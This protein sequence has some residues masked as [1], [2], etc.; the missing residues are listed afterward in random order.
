MATKTRKIGA[1]GNMT[2]ANFATSIETFPDVDTRIKAFEATFKLKGQICLDL[3]RN[4]V[5]D[6][7][8]WIARMYLNAGKKEIGEATGTQLDRVVNAVC[9][10]AWRS[11]KNLYPNLAETNTR[12]T[13]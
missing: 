7:M 12:R 4:L 13:A 11:L 2:A 1:A 10:D 6:R 9:R 3:S 8:T 5:N